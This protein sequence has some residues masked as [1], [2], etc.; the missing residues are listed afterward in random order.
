MPPSVRFMFTMA[1]EIDGSS[2]LGVA[3]GD[4]SG[5]HWVVHASEQLLLPLLSLSSTYRVLPVASTRYLPC[6]AEFATPRSAPDWL[7]WSGT[8]AGAVAA[9]V[10]VLDGADVWVLGAWY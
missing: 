10:P 1:P 2:A 5:G 4:S 3:A 7:G 8:A 9:G 6:S